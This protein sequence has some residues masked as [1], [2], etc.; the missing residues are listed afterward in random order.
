M[1]FNKKNS[2]RSRILYILAVLVVIGVLCTVA[3]ARHYQW[4]PFQQTAIEDLASREKQNK[5]DSTNPQSKDESAASSKDVDKSKNTSEVPISETAK[6]E[7]L[8]LAQEN[9]EVIYSAAVTNGS[10]GGTCSAVFTHELAKP[11]ISTTSA[12]N[13][14]CGPTSIPETEFSALGTW[15]LTLRYYTDNTQAVATQ[16]VEVR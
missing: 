6:L 3:L 7:I 9:R 12:H 8:K 13:G 15:T 5:S 16:T 1:N 2:N 10:G 14:K 4:G 11:V